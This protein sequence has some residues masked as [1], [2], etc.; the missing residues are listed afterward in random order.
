MGQGQMYEVKQ[1][2]MLGPALGS[3]QPQAMLQAWGSMAGKLP[4]EKD[5]GGCWWTAS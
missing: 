2:Q 1:G 3:Q 5:L 4:G